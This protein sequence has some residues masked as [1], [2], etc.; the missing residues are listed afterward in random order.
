MPKVKEVKENEVSPI[1]V[2]ATSM[3]EQHDFTKYVDEMKEVKSMTE[4]SGWIL[5]RAS[6]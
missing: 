3:L 2:E 1:W 4:K 5:V 6:R